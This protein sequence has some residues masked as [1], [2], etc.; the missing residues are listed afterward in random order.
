M[1]GIGEGMS[2]RGVPCGKE[3]EGNDLPSIQQLQYLSRLPLFITTTI[4][5]Y[6]G[7]WMIISRSLHANRTDE[8]HK[9]PPLPWNTIRC[10]SH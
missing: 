4:T 10:P 6:L 9:T 5:Y 3:I 2:D 7:F 8:R 1:A